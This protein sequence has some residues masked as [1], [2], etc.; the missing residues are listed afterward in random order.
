M[1]VKSLQAHEQQVEIAQQADTGLEVLDLEMDP[2]FARRPVRIRAV[3]AHMEALR[4]LGQV[5]LENP[6]TILQEL[7][8]VAIEV[9]GADSAGISIER[10][11]ATD[12]R[13][14]EWVATAGVYAPFLKAIL[15]RKPSAC[16]ICLER[17]RPQLFKVSQPFFD[18]M[19]VDAATVTDGILLPWQVE[20]TRGTIWILAHG[21]QEAFDATDCQV[22]QVLANFAAM[23]VRQ[24][25]QQK[26]LLQQAGAAAAAAM[27]NDLAHGINNPL[28]S[29]TN[30]LYLAREGHSGGD[31]R[32]L[33][34]ELSPL[35]KRISSLVGQL[36]TL[37]ATT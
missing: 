4:Q 15:P 5:L 34:M 30:L 18:L 24:Q 12:E 19:A 31:A 37:P 17:G 35:L 20:G 36:L 29:L 8:N 11:D 14:Y 10:T 28:Q 33:A 26:L 6:D 23:G 32:S 9:C 25:A 13:C 21:R 22:M 1:A 27:A 7:T 16:G 3:T 2:S